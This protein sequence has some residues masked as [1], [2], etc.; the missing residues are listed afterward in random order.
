LD[1]LGQVEGGSGSFDHRQNLTASL[2]DS[3]LC[4]PS[5]QGESDFKRFLRIP[6]VEKTKSLCLLF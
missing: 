1:I 4:I 2:K 3:N 5:H 6:G